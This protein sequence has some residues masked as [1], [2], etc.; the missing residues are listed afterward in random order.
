MIVIIIKGDIHVTGKG[1]LD[2]GPVIEHKYDEGDIG[3]AELGTGVKVGK[4][5]S[6]DRANATTGGGEDITAIDRIIADTHRPRLLRQTSPESSSSYLPPLDQPYLYTTPERVSYK[7]LNYDERSAPE[8]LNIPNQSLNLVEV[9][10]V[11]I[12]MAERA[13]SYAQGG[14]TTHSL[15]ALVLLCTHCT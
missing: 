3:E 5:V 8:P 15:L 6:I 14:K 13:L 10:G 12:A 2:I 11:D 9:F 1:S 4:W 7:G